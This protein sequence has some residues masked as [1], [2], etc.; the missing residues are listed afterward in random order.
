MTTL[1]DAYAAMERGSRV[2]SIRIPRRDPGPADVRIDVAYAGV[3]HSDPLQIDGAWGAGIFPMVPGHESSGIVTEVG[4]EVTRFRVGDRVGI[5]NFVDSCRECDLCHKGLEHYCR[6][7]IVTYNG[8]DKAGDPTYGGYSRSIV[9]D[10]KYLARIPEGLDLASAAPLMCAGITVYS[11]M[12]QHGVGPGTKLG[13][14]GMGGLGH[15]AVKFAHALGA[16]V[17]VLSQGNSKKDDALAFG[18]SDFRTTSDPSTF[19][20]LAEHFDII[21]CTVSAALN[22]DQLLSLV[23]FG[24]TFVNLGAP[25]GPVSLGMSSL[26]RSRISFTSSAIGSIAQTE[27]MLDYCVRHDITAEVETISAEGINHALDTLR[28]KSGSG[29]RYRYVIDASTI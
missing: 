9:V 5:G 8:H 26:I 17:T 1:T 25:D 29:V 20:D 6:K 21:I 28:H 13:V 23:R 3:C 19:T 12:R 7:L 11:P 16:E 10:E 2:T 27:E 24:G 22:F 4:A 15:L 18:A 14:V